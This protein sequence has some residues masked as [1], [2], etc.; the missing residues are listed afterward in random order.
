LKKITDESRVEDSIKLKKIQVELRSLR[1][2]YK[3]LQ[4]DY[5]L[6]TLTNEELKRN[7][8]ELM[9][10]PEEGNSMNTTIKPKQPSK[11]E[12]TFFSLFDK[13]ILKEEKNLLE[14][15]IEDLIQ[16]NKNLEQIISNLKLEQEEIKK[17]ATNV[18]INNNLNINN[19]NTVDTTEKDKQLNELLNANK[20]LSAKIETFKS[21]FEEINKNIESLKKEKENLNKSIKEKEGIYIFR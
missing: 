19:N 10:I 2:N 17:T 6:I 18:I 15:K 13:G 12:T 11:I 14:K 16:Q 4:E 5:E 1:L 3:S 9:K 21:K 7:I 20:D 8:Y